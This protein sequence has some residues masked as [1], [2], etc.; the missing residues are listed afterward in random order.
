MKYARRVAGWL[1]LGGGLAGVVLLAWCVP[2]LSE[3]LVLDRERIAGREFWRWFTYPW[4]HFSVAHLA[5]DLGCFAG[6]IGLA[7]RFG[8]RADWGWLV[9]LAAVAAGVGATSLVLDPRLDRL[10]GLSGVNVAL[11]MRV[12]LM[13]WNRG[14][15][16]VAAGL[17][18]G[19]GLKLATESI[20]IGGLIQFGQVGVEAFQPSH[21]AGAVWAL[22]LEVGW[23]A[24]RALS[25]AKNPPPR[26]GLPRKN[27]REPAGWR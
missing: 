25:T 18:L 15:R 10:G 7:G 14:E 24:G 19:L 3:L 20:G 17:V 1:W 12:G 27:H 22:L 16:V 2:G 13:L 8:L 5:V 26:D 6:L 4:V 21:W 9:W 23:Q 11:G